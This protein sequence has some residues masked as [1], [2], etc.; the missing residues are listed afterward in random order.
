[1]RYVK[2]L[3]SSFI[4]LFRE[5]YRIKHFVASL[6]EIHSCQLFGLGQMY[7]K[8]VARMGMTYG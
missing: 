8:H 4:N 7:L 6:F 5:Y 1:M 3:Y 2:E